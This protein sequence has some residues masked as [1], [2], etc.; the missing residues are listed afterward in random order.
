MSEHVFRDLGFA[1]APSLELKAEIA[2]RV[3]REIEKRKLTQIEAAKLLGAKQPKISALMNG[4][5]SGFSIER[6]LIFL[7]R[8]GHDV[9]IT[10]KPHKS[11]RKDK[12][13]A[14]RFEQVA[15]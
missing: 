7:T 14:I 6:L 15:A 1:D 11:R 3:I 4:K 2:L 9:T 8:L 10:H 12:V 13:G 5:I